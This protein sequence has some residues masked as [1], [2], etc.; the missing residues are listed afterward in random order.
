MNPDR[1]EEVC[2]RIRDGLA[3]AM[4][5][6]ILF[7]FN[8]FA[9]CEKADLVGR[10]RQQFAFRSARFVMSSQCDI[11]MIILLIGVIFKE[12]SAYARC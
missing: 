8:F 2:T 6:Q 4:M 5:E 3:V 12:S 9:P 10:R 11:S 7:F 1:Q